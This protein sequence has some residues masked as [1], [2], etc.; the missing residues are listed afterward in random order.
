[1]TQNESPFLKFA[2]VG[3]YYSPLPDLEDIRA[4]RDILFR[5]MKSCPGVNLQE[6]EQVRLLSQFSKYFSEIPFPENKTPTQ[7]YYFNNDFFCHGD[8]TILYSIMRYFKPTTIIEAGS[9][10][11]SAAM[12]D[13]NDLFFE[14][15]IKLKFIEPYPERLNTLLSNT[16]KTN[17]ILVA[18]NLQEVPINEFQELQENDILFLDSTHI[19]K[20]GS[21]VMY[22]L[23]EVLPTL[24][25]G[26]I[27]HFHDIFWPF[28]YPEQWFYEGR[29]WNESYFLRAFLQYNDCFEILYFNSYMAERHTQQVEEKLPL[30]LRN[31]GGSL[32]LKKVK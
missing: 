5:S 18:T 17:N 20:I 31:P 25:K 15:Q 19:V 4:R 6:Q 29:A 23:F 22:L 1:M 32:W 13:I 14:K 2:P 24:N 12:L 8:A 3:H 9:G 10:F 30:C 11:S 27:V 26:V 16:D 21:D 28:E 7:R